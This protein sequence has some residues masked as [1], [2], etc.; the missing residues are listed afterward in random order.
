MRFLQI[1][2]TIAPTHASRANVTDVYVVNVDVTDAVKEADII[3]V[4]VT[5]ADDTNIDDYNSNDTLVEN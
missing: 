4:G 2:K 5:G 3:D 1:S